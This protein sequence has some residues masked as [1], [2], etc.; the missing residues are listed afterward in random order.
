MTSE[1]FAARIEAAVMQDHGT[2]DH[3]I[4][5]LDKR[6]EIEVD[7][8]IG[9]VAPE[10]IRHGQK[11][12]AGEV[13]EAHVPWLDR[14]D[15]IGLVDK[16]HPVPNGMAALLKTGHL[17]RACVGMS[18]EHFLDLVKALRLKQFGDLVEREAHHLE[19]VDD[20]DAQNRLERVIA[21]FIIP[22]AI[23][24]EKIEL[25]V[26]AQRTRR[27]AAQLACL[28]NTQKLTVV[29]LVI[30]HMSHLY[31]SRTR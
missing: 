31:A 25:V 1:W 28:A 11:L 12:L 17:A 14:K 29:Q 4:V 8:R 21:V 26:M 16:P 19:I 20:G 30:A 22:Y 5:L 18:T 9:V 24:L 23:G 15:K 27:D 3:V 2:S 13:L 7:D 10:V 6:G